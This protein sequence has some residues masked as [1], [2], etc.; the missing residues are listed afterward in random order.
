MP[1]V[2][3]EIVTCPYRYGLRV[4]CARGWESL[5]TRQA[6]GFMKRK[7]QLRVVLCIVKVHVQVAKHVSANI[8]CMHSVAR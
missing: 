6:E 8:N 3:G 1:T 5:F 4:V 2:S 7:K